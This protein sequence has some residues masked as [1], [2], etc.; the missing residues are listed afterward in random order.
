MRVMA[1]IKISS[2]SDMVADEWPWLSAVET[3]TELGNGFL[4]C[5]VLLSDFLSP[6]DAWPIGL[7]GLRSGSHGEEDSFSIHRMSDS[8]ET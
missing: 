7:D 8:N 3:G 2:F 5:T 6:L 4:E 1:G